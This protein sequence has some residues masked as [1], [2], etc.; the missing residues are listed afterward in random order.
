MSNRDKKLQTKSSQKTATFIYVEKSLQIYCLGKKKLKE[1]FQ[2]FINKFN[3]KSEIRDYLFSYEGKVI[4]E[5]EYEKCVEDNNFGKKDSFIITVKKQIKIIQCPMCNY[6]DCVVSLQNYRTIFYNCEHKHLKIS[7]YENYEQDQLYYPEKI[8]CSGSGDK[9]KNNALIDQNFRL[10]LTCSNLIGRTR[11][12][13]NKCVDKEKKEF[14]GDNEHKIIK[15][16]DKNYYCQDHI[17]EMKSY[18]FDCKCNLCDVCV[19]LHL[20][21]KETE[22]HRIKSIESLIPEEKE[23]DEIKESLRKIKESMVSLNKIIDNLIYTL[24]RSLD[25]YR[26]Y[27]NI[28]TQVLKKYETFNKKPEDF[29]N[30]TIFKCLYNLKKSNKQMLGDIQSVI[31]GKDNAE[32]AIKLIKIYD[33]KKKEYYDKDKWGDDLNKEN[34]DNWFKEVCEREERNRNRN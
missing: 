25:I 12:I 3:P 5:S 18:C 19:T 15:Y 2:D 22:G 32:K 11:S 30:F 7:S 20:N 10:C 8:L 24:G 17:S 26:D 1:L 6:G 14:K 21:D 28:A 9:C 29:K 13:C 27:Y 34:D 23:I 16:E 31:H 4:E 33:N